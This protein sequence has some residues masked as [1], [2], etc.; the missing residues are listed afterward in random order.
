MSYKKDIEQIEKW[1]DTTIKYLE[2][3]AAI[4]EQLGPGSFE[5]AR[6]GVQPFLQTLKICAT[7]MVSQMKELRVKLNIS[8]ESVP[9]ITEN[10]IPFKKIVQR[11]PLEID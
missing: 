3:S 11:R 1:C 4:L 7:N 10:V 5:I 2:Q 6:K 8:N 9:E